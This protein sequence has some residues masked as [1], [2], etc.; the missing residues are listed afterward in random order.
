MLHPSVSAERGRQIATALLTFTHDGDAAVTGFTIPADYRS[1]ATVLKAN[2]APPFENK[3]QALLAEI[4]R[5][6][7]AGVI[8]GI[9]ALVLL[10]TAGAVL[11]WEHRRLRRSFQ[12]LGMLANASRDAVISLDSRGAIK[13]WGRTADRLF[14]L[15]MR[16]GARFI[17]EAFPDNTHPTLLKL[18]RRTLEEQ[19]AGTEQRCESQALDAQGQ[20]FPVEVVLKLVQPNAKGP[21]TAALAFVRDL[22]PEL[23]QLL[24]TRLM[25]S[26]FTHAREGITITDPKGNILDVNP[27]F[28]SITGYERSEVLGR[29]PRVLQS[30]RQSAE[31]FQNLWNTL[32]S[33]GQWSGEIWNRRKSGEIY[34]E[35]LSISAVRDEHEELHHF[36]AV[37]TDITELKRHQQ[38]LEQVA[39]FD[40][41]TGLPNRALLS[42][43]LSQATAHAH[44]QVRTLGVDFALDDFGTGY[45]SLAYLKHLPIGTLKIDQSFVRGMAHSAGD[46]AIVEAVISLAKVFDRRVI[47]EGV[48]N[49]HLAQLLVELGCELGQGYAFSKPIPAEQIP[50]WIAAFENAAART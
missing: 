46:R 42:D 33:D 9:S 28:T 5:T 21:Q 2:N 12:R 18:L 38:R 14:G 43:R 27:A 10:M 22:R 26:V 25:T 44:R 19:T 34:P 29:N 4:W 15:R 6:H 20:A 50:G 23:T 39:H 47:A 1:V 45:S 49:A 30:G 41:L 8:G 24:R 32:L 40:A 13:L 31:F 11:A 7:Q 37:F 17:Q 3:G 36:V 35:I 48:E 16:R